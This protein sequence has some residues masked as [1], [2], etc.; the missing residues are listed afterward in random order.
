MMKPPA[1][2]PCN[3]CPWRRKSLPGWLGPHDASVW[4]A[5]AHSDQPIACHLTLVEDDDSDARHCAG[6]DVYRSNVLKRPRVLDHEQ[7]PVDR[8]TVFARPDEFRVHH[9]RGFIVDELLS[10]TFASSVS[11][12]S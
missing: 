5:L 2:T 4:L 3:D 1:K 11:E 12:S 6:A 9:E 7:L 10:G 8:E